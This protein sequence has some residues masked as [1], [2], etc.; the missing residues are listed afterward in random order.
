VN[1]KMA[2]NI[3]FVNSETLTQFKRK[4]IVVVLIALIIGLPT[5]FYAG[6]YAA[7]AYPSGATPVYEHPISDYN[8]LIWKDGSTYYAKNGMVGTID[9]SGTNGATVIQNAL[10]ALTRGGLVLL[11]G[12]TFDLGTTQIQL[13]YDGQRLRGL[14]GSIVP[15]TEI[16]YS[17]TDYAI[18]VAKANVSNALY[19]FEVGEFY[20]GVTGGS[21]SGILTYNA[22][23]GIVHDVYIEGAVIGIK[24]YGCWESEIM[25][26]EI[27]SPTNRGIWVDGEVA[28]G[29]HL[30][31]IE[32]NYI[33]GTPY[34]IYIDDN[35]SNPLGI[36][37]RDND[38]GFVNSMVGVLVT[39]QTRNLEITGNHFEEGVGLT[40]TVQI[41]LNG[42]GY[43]HMRDTHITGNTFITSNTAIYID[44]AIGV[45]IYHNIIN[46]Y[47]GSAVFVDTLTSNHAGKVMVDENYISDATVSINS[48]SYVIFD[49]M[50]GNATISGS[51]SVLVNHYLSGT[52]T[53]IVI[54]PR[55]SGY[56][57]FFT[58]VRTAT[59]FSINV[60]SSGTYVFDWYAEIS[61]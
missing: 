58:G 11:V 6:Y 4:T 40:N 17:G 46:G 61:R 12:R 26:C 47:G 27:R 14:S 55:S 10:D 56:G 25:H 21:G 23:W 20:L 29:S 53:I 60:T 45:Y 39:Y 8:Y 5:F 13:K 18:K 31:R 1:E 48:Y 37:I 35:A 49:K 3:S 36:K 15:E 51:T 16:T 42:V 22:H 54:T 34:G 28:M 30:L 59:Q 38:F 19:G 52:P 24:S 57:D 7:R 41:R 32:D 43:K 33:D 2:K 44:Y 50:S 9:Y